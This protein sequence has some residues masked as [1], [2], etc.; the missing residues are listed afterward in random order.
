MT[1]PALR[2]AS[3]LDRLIPPEISGD[4]FYRWLARIAATPGVH[5]ILEIGSS[6][7]EGSTAALVEGALRNPAAPRIHCIEVS[8][9]R[10]Q[11][12]AERYRSFDFVHCHNVSSVPAERFPTEAELDAFRRRIWTRFRFIR[13]DTVMGWLRQD[14][15]YLE[16][17][18]LSGAGIREIMERHGIDRWDAVL[19]DGSEFT[20]AAEMEEVYGAR[21]LLLDDIRTFKNHDNHARLAKDPAYR[22]VARSRWLRNGFA[23][24]ERRPMAGS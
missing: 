19:I 6:S 20:G 14:L 12:L 15:A 18:G 21:F 7:G 10:H 3:T 5:T 1:E 9:A 8:R 2:Q 4:R 23:I 22:L 11:A 13:R 16:R 17:S 24:F